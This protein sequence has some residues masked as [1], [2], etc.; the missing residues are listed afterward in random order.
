VEGRDA[1]EGRFA[2]VLTLHLAEASGITRKLDVPVVGRVALVSEGAGEPTSKLGGTMAF[3][4]NLDG[5]WGK[6]NRNG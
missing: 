6:V 1:P 5:N 3:V 2:E 4:A